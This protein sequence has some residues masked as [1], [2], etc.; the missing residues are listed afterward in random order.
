[1]A[2]HTHEAPVQGQ[3]AIVTGA[4]QGIGRA[5]ALRLASDGM[6]IVIADVKQ[7]PA[8]ALA[9][10]IRATGRRALAIVSDVAKAAAREQLIATTLAEFGRLD[11]LVNNAGIQRASAPLEVTEDHW[12]MMMSVN[13]KAIYFL[14]QSAMNHFMAQR[15]GRI[16][17]IASMAGKAASTIY[18]P[19]YNV[20]KAAVIAMTK[21]FAHIGASSGVRVNAICPG[22]IE[23]PMQDLVDSEFGRLMGREPA[24]VRADR[25]ARIPIGRPGDPDDVAAVVSFLAGPDSGYMTGQALNVTGGMLMY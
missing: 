19:V 15:S 9:E 7:A 11:V 14:C 23:T 17:N 20:S 13:A 22:V 25:T 4:G 8:E 12:D 6:D 3:V 24:Q 21:T 10:E 2:G 18:H 1:M 16:V 5:I